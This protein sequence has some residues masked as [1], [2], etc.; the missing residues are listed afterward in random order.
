MLA[1]FSLRKGGGRLAKMFIYQNM[2]PI[3]PPPNPPPPYISSERS[4]N[5]Q[6]CF[7]KERTAS[8]VLKFSG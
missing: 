2:F 1:N 6:K 5:V 4:L 3:P 8:A 7:R